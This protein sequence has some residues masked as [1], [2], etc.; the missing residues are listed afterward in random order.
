MKN[1]PVKYMNLPSVASASV[2]SKAPIRCCG[3]GI[4]CCS[5]WVREL[6]LGSCFVMWFLVPF[7]DL[8]PSCWG[9]ESWL[10]YFNSVLAV[11]YSC[12]SS[13]CDG[14]VCVCSISLSFSLVLFSAAVVSNI[15]S[16]TGLFS[17]L[18]SQFMKNK[19]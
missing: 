16:H 17:L 5:H 19:K 8:R 15:I 12:P 9:R 4:C 1:R 10:L 11:M 13:Q 14:L 3:F 6:V 7:V 2:R 18:H